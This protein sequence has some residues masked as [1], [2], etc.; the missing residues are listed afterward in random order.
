M[1]LTPLAPCA[2]RHN[3][4]IYRHFD[5]HQRHIDELWVKEGPHLWLR[6]GIYIPTPAR[7]DA[8]SKA[9]GWVQPE[10]GARGMAVIEQDR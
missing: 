7:L 5:G 9:G 1:F 4:S 10:R 2:Q 8:S 6:S 3:P